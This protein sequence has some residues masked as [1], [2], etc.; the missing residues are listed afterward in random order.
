[1][2]K[3][4]V[5]HR[6]HLLYLDPDETGASGAGDNYMYIYVLGLQ[7]YNYLCQTRSIDKVLSLEKYR[8]GTLMIHAIHLSC[9]ICYS[10][11]LCMTSSSNHCR[12]CKTRGRQH[13]LE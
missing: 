6:K 3:R 10:L 7:V 4:G 2:R 1:M 8:I 9:K 11:L 12:W 5:L 13:S